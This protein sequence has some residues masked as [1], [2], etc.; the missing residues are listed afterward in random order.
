VPCHES[1]RSVLYEHAPRLPGWPRSQFQRVSPLGRDRASMGRAAHSFERRPGRVDVPCQHGRLIPAGHHVVE[2]EVAWAGGDHAL[3]RGGMC[4]P[5]GS[6]GCGDPPDPDTDDPQGLD[7]TSWSRSRTVGT[8][9]GCWEHEPKAGGSGLPRRRTGRSLAPVRAVRGG[10]RQ[11]VAVRRR[12]AACLQ[13][14]VRPARSGR[15]RLPELADAG[16]RVG[17]VNRR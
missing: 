4:E 13:C 16:R 15:P 3:E 5:R 1:P 10:D 17:H 6:P 8:A 7:V 9:R 11:S 2:D 14:D 12:A